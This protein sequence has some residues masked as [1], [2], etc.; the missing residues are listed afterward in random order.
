LS[1]CRAISYEN[2]IVVIVPLEK[3]GGRRSNFISKLAPILRDELLKA[4]YSQVYADIHESRRYYLQATIALRAGEESSSVKWIFKFEDHILD[5]FFFRCVSEFPPSVLCHN[6]L[7]ELISYDQK[8]N[9]S[10]CET[11]RVYLEND[12]SPTLTMKALHIHRSTLKYRIDRI[13]AFLSDELDIENKDA[14][15]CILLQLRLFEMGR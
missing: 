7:L 8:N 3:W 4:G 14:K 5:Y 12:S 15:L 6:A 10:F 2:K 11:L 1:N 13:K 9:T